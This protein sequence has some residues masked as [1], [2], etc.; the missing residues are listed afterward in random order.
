MKNK[1]DYTLYLCTDREL[2]STDTIE[3]C[4]ELAIMGGCTIV[5]LR[6]KGGSFQEYFHLAK[7]VK[8]I[9]DKYHIPLIIND[10]ADIAIAVMA[11]GVHVGQGDLPAKVARKIIGNDKILGISVS[12]L[13]EA[14]QAEKDGADYIGVGAMYSTNTK[15]DAVL[16]SMEELKAIRDNVKVPIVVIGGINK[17]TAGNFSGGLADG[18]AV[19]SAIISQ[20]DVKQAAEELKGIFLANQGNSSLFSEV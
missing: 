3:E 4:V 11:D 18:I 17:E 19:V 6:E 2:M 20:K 8:E 13:E 9:T 10:R 16:V 15:T 7:S 14:V 12:T 1:A 5:Q